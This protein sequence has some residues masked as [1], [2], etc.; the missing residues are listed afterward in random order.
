MTWSN[1][2]IAV[3]WGTTNRR[4]YRLDAK[5][6]MTGEHEDDKGAL[7]VGRDGFA[8]AAAQ[9]RDLLGDLPM[10]LGGMAGSTH[11]WVDAPYRPCPLS[12][13]DL[14][15]GLVWVEPGRTAIVPGAKVDG[16][17]RSDIM[18]GEEIQLLG[19]AA[20]GIVPPTC[21]V[22]HPGTHCKWARLEDGRLVDFHTAMTG[23][24]FAL[25]RDHSILAGQLAAE[26][27]DDSMFARGVERGLGGGLLT[28]D[29]FSV[30]ADV[31]LGRI[32]ADEAPS[33]MSGLLI[34][35]DVAEGIRR[36][37]G[38][39]ADILVMGRPS[40]TRLYAKAIAMAGAAA[41]QVDGERAFVAG[42]N[43][44]VEHVE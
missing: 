24:M 38:T 22:C 20:A 2:F 26:V 35:A 41:R 5:G 12:A 15:S 39:T 25:L 3:D 27:R 14:V 7:A 21:I 9:L 23:E 30:R 29:I 40:L 17:G 6:R 37:N 28:S 18:R 32:G 19:A 36:A 44:I 10:L 11:G 33:L 42:A 31:L 4:A 13:A 43:L 34:G 1:G 16:D 8:A